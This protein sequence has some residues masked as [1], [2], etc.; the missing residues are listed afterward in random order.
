MGSSGG[1]PGIP[2]SA[3]FFP[4]S[5][6]MGQGSFQPWD[7]GAMGQQAGIPSM[8]AGPQMPMGVL[9]ALM[10]QRSAAPK[11]QQQRYAMQGDMRRYGS[12]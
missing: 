1:I 2:A 3:G 12:R 4:M 8:P 5:P 6:M 9:P 11:Q 10:Q 7:M